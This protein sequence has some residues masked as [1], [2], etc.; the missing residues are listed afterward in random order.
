MPPRLSC[1]SDK[2]LLM[3]GSFRSLLNA[4]RSAPTE[5][6]GVSTTAQTGCM[7]ELMSPHETLLQYHEN[8]DTT[9]RWWNGPVE[10]PATWQCQDQV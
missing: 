2:D 10:P 7:L 4:A 3:F 6:P 1:Y 9:L 8:M 5:G